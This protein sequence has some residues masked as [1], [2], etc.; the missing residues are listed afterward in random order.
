MDDLRVFFTSYKSPFKRVGVCINDIMIMELSYQSKKIRYLLFAALALTTGIWTQAAETTIRLGTQ[1]GKLRY[2][3]ETLAVKPGV[4]VVLTFVN[5][6]EMQHNLL[7]LQGEEGITLKVAQ[8]AWA[9]GPGAAEKQF[10]P[11]MDGVVLVHSR[12]LDPGQEE[13]LRFKA[14]NQKGVYPYV[15]TLPGHAFSMKGKMIV[16]DDPGSVEIAKPDTDQS[17]KKDFVLHPHHKPIVKRAFV[18]DGPP[19]AINVGIPGGINYC[20]DAE[21]C[22]VAFG[23]FGPFLD[24]GPDWGRNANERGGRPVRVLG[25]RFDAGQPM[26]PIRIGGKNIPSQVLFKGYRLRGMNAPTME[27]TVNGAWVKETISPAEQGIG[28]KYAFELDPGLVTPVYVY[29]DRQDAEVKV[30][31]GKWEG[32]WLKIDPEDIASFSITRFHQP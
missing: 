2:D 10:V 32:S 7:I 28:L 27:F 6:D 17:Q 19:R 12:V 18:Q 26:F 16:T 5:N 4:D 20:F 24:I 11:D 30:S 1:P 23:W 21:T 14:P 22:T 3:L 29:I 31:N 8:K 9:M 25:E 15:C 13:T